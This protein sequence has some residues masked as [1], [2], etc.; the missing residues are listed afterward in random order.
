MNLT[1]K[2]HVLDNKTRKSLFSGTQTQC[3]FFVEEMG[4]RIVADC[5]M[6]LA[7]YVR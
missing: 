1:H 2:M 6:G 3:E 4:L 5:P 7:M